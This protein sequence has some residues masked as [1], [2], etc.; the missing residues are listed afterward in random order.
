[1]RKVPKK[2]PKEFQP[3][4]PGVQAGD[5]VHIPK[6]QWVYSNAFTSLATADSQWSQDI[7]SYYV[8]TVAYPAMGNHHVVL[9]PGWGEAHAEIFRL[10]K[11]VPNQ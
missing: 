9:F 6:N 2:N 1:M 10:K 8:N 11:N 4:N 5:I 7:H 3:K